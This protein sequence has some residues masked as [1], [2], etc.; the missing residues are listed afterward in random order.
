MS[1]TE[2]AVGCLLILFCAWLAWNVV[3]WLVGLLA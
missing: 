1:E 3:N 2:V